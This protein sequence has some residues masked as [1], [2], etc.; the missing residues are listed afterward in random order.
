MT[1]KRQKNLVFT[2][3]VFH[4]FF[5]FAVL[6]TLVVYTLPTLKEVEK[7]KQD[8]YTLVSQY[9]TMKDKWVS[10]EQYSK[11]L[12]SSENTSVGSHVE[13]NKE[14]YN[15]NLNNDSGNDFLIFL[16]KKQADLNAPEMLEKIKNQEAKLSK[17]LPT[18]IE[19]KNTGEAGFI[20]DFIFINYVEKIMRGFQLNY[21]WIVGIWELKIV[22]EYIVDGKKSNND[23]NIYSI[24]LK[25]KLSGGKKEILDF[26]YFVENVWNVELKQNQEDETVSFS[27]QEDKQSRLTYSKIRSSLK[28][29][30]V[31]E[32]QAIDIV[33]IRMKQY[34]D[35]SYK[36][37]NI[38]FVDFIKQTQGNQSYT[39]EVQLEFFVKGLPEYKLKEYINVF[40]THYSFL[41]KITKNALKDTKID[42][43][44]K[45]RYNT[46]YNTLKE[47][48]KNISSLKKAISSKKDLSEMYILVDDYQNT[49][50]D[51]AWKIGYDN[52]YKQFKIAYSAQ[53]PDIQKRLWGSNKEIISILNTMWEKVNQ[54]D[55]KLEKSKNI[56][57]YDYESLPYYNYILNNL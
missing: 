20:T 24:P 52:V 28:Q 48:S 11:K 13:L 31:F 22:D 7:E 14:F 1:N 53:S 6:I 56:N 32:N 46:V 10:Y 4:M 49:L 15:E 30:N 50:I 9:N 21:E 44:D 5:F 43:I 51:L 57:K 40:F 17:V 29:V 3:F 8:T 35:A 41:Q 54:I 16:D 36:S 38:D 19:K 27:I 34:L 26:L 55:A 37:R 42:D 45:I 23:M 33:E 2:S 18:Y 47:M 39:I 12:A 25:L